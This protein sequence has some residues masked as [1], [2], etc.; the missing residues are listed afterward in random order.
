LKNKKNIIPSYSKEVGISESK[1]DNPVVGDIMIIETK[2]L[3]LYKQSNTM[4]DFVKN[5]LIFINEN[6][7]GDIKLKMVQNPDGS[8]DMWIVN[9]YH[10]MIENSEQTTSNGIKS[11]L[12]ESKFSDDKLKHY[13]NLNLMNSKN[14][15][16]TIDISSDFSSNVNMEAFF[17]M[18]NN[19]YGLNKTAIDNITSFMNQNDEY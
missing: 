18:G 1:E 12:Y 17:T 5:I 16:E 4:I 8:N 13:I 7:R 6:V 15:I 10:Y 11:E 3:E 2:I 19:I 9:E 14:L